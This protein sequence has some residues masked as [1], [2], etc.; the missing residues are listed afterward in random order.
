MITGIE[1][2]EIT[3]HILKVCHE[4]YRYFQKI[5]NV[6][7]TIAIFLKEITDFSAVLG[8]IQTTVTQLGESGFIERCGKEHWQAIGNSLRD[9]EDSLQ[10]LKLLTLQSDRGPNG[11]L[12]SLF[13]K[14]KDQIRLDSNAFDIDLRQKEISICRKVLMLSLNMVQMYVFLKRIL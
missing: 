3:G 4:L 11:I 13:W 12:Q 6:D 9:I 1:I 8:N 7:S 2:V 5:E 10:N 14:T